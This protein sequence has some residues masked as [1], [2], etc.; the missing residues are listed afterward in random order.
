LLRKK[1]ERKAMREPHRPA[2]KASQ[3]KPKKKKR[4]QGPAW[5][6]PSIGGEPHQFPQP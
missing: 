2:I 6:A 1:E 5:T 4:P 3:N